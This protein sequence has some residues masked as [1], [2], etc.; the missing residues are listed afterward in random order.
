MT[1]NAVPQPYRVNQDAPKF[2]PGEADLFANSFNQMWWPNSGMWP[3]AWLTVYLCPCVLRKLRT[4]SAILCHLCAVSTT[5]ESRKN[6]PLV[7]PQDTFSR[8]PFLL[9]RY[10][11][12]ELCGGTLGVVVALVVLGRPTASAVLMAIM[13]VTK[14]IDWYTV[15]NKGQLNY[16]SVSCAD[17]CES[18]SLLSD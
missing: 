9:P 15:Q 14:I 17:F 7:A 4:A 1:E 12:L 6:A 18:L 2:L 10:E 5:T 11:W 8:V 13:N 3:D 16:I